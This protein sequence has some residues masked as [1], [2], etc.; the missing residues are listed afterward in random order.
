MFSPRVPSP[1]ALHLCRLGRMSPSRGPP[2]LCALL[3]PPAATDS[4]SGP[5][6]AARPRA[7]PGCGGHS[8]RPWNA[9]A[10]WSPRLGPARALS[11]RELVLRCHVTQAAARTL[12]C[13]WGNGHWDVGVPTL[14]RSSRKAQ[15]ISEFQF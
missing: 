10:P 11:D 2:D 4:T 8:G 15:E 5:G 14:P 1:V 12:T 9:L 6:V 13:A 7:L 3:R